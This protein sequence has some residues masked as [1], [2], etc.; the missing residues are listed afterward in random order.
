[1]TSIFSREPT[2]ERIS[3]RWYVGLQLQKK[4]FTY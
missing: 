3:R 2:E 1:M 4:G